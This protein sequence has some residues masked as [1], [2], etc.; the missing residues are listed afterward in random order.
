MAATLAWL[1]LPMI[2]LVVILVKGFSPFLAANWAI[3]CSFLLSF[4]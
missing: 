1:L 2:V 3:A 4:F